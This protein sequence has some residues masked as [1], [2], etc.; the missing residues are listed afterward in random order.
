[1]EDMFVVK[2]IGLENYLEYWVDNHDAIDKTALRALE[3]ND[4]DVIE[5]IIVLEEDEK[6][7]FQ[8]NI[9]YKAT[10]KKFLMQ[11]MGKAQILKV[12]RAFLNAIKFARENEISENYLFLDL[13]YIFV[14]FMT[15]ELS[16]VYIP[17]N[18]QKIE[19][20]QITNFLREVLL[21][22]TY[23]AEE[24][25]LYIAE[26][27]LFL[28][29][30]K[31]I[32][33]GEFE[34]LIERLEYEENSNLNKAV[35]IPQQT[36]VPSFRSI[37]NQEVHSF[38]KPISNQSTTVP[39]TRIK[40]QEK[41]VYIPKQINIDLAKPIS[42]SLISDS[43]ATKDSTSA[44]TVLTAESD[45]IQPPKPCL[46]RSRNKEK[47]FIDKDIFKIGKSSTDVDYQIKDNQAISRI[48]AIIQKKNGV[49]YLRDND[50]T[51]N[52]FVNSVILK[53]EKEQML[54]KGMKIAFAD[55]E[56]IYELV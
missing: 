11:Q 44:T 50:S 36:A 30:R 12:F 49:C 14:D 5:S 41:N 51:N 26:L 8:Y 38:T 54:L 45:M 34:A 25:I 15:H 13:N 29:Q 32:D 40:N 42:G 31:K 18:D 48:H 39:E 2:N 35:L 4:S 6:L 16:F 3:E 24:N 17:V 22:I 46:V 55:E 10:L 20:K 47:I 52:T 7:G 23:K 53:G 33:I 9:A 1:M 43:S 37:P 19:S 56:F 28:S 21:N 27:T